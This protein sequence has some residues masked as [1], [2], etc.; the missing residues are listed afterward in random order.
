[1][2]VSFHAEDGYRFISTF[3]RQMNEVSRQSSTL[4]KNKRRSKVIHSANC[5]TYLHSQA[6]TTDDMYDDFL[7][8]D[9]R[10]NAY[11]VICNKKISPGKHE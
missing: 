11:V 7:P 1:M 6:A 3:N 10:I 9:D 8:P 4:S 5:R 2:L